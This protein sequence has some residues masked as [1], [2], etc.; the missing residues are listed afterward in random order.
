MLLWCIARPNPI[1]HL[2]VLLK[3]LKMR[4]VLCKTVIYMDDHRNKSTRADHEHQPF[5]QSILTELLGVGGAEMRRELCEQLTNDFRRI[6]RMMDT[7]ERHDLA[8]ASHELK[9]LAAT[10]GAS[11]LAE[12]AQTLNS[13][14]GSADGVV[15]TIMSKQIRQEIGQVLD[16]L[17]QH[18]RS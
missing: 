18:D 8:A 15:L 5:D 2:I 6:A 7:D 10:I 13:I 3:P 9:G 17:R 4:G 11:R 1:P 12:N 16:A 14:A